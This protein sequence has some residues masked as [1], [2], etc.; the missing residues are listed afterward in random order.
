MVASGTVSDPYFYLTTLLLNTTSTNGAQNNTFQDSSSNTFPLTRAPV[1]GPNAP[2]QGSF[3]PFSQTGWSNYFP[4]NTSTSQTTLT[5]S[6][7]AFGTGN[8]TIELNYYLIAHASGNVGQIYESG[9]NGIGILVENTNQLRVF[10][11]DGAGTSTTLIASGAG[12]AITV[13]AWSFIS[14]I[15]TGTAANQLNLYVN[16][17][18]V[19][20]GT[21]SANYTST[22]GYING[23]YTGA[24]YFPV[25]C[26][27]SNLRVSTTNR[28]ITVPTAF[29]TSDAS[30][31]L[32]TCISNRFVNVV[33]GNALT[34]LSTAAVEPSVQAFSPFAP[35]TAYSTSVIGGSGFFDGTG[36]YLTV[37]YNAAL[38]LDTGDFC[39]EAYVYKTAASGNDWKLLSGTATAPGMFIGDGGTTSSRGLGWGSA[40]AGWTF[41]SGVY[42]PVN[43][44]AHICYT[45]LSGVGRIFLNGY[46][47]AYTA[48]NTTNLSL[49]SSTLFIC[50]DYTN[51]Y[52][53]QG[54]MSNLRITK[55]SVPTGYQTSATTP[56]AT[57][58]IFVPP[59]A[60]VTQTSQGA[61][62]PALI[63]NSINA[64]I[65]DVSAKNN[66]ETVGNAQ[67]S[68]TQTKFGTTSMAY[69][70]TGDY[71]IIPD[72]PNLQ[73]G[74]G[75]F[76][77]D[78]FV[79]LTAAGVAYGIISKGA[80]ATGWSV[81]V[82]SGNKLQF[83]YTA[84][85]LTGA[86]SLAATTWYYFAVTRSGSASGN[87]KLYL[88]T[89]GST[90]LD[91]TSAGAVTDNFNQT[92]RMYVGA[93]RT[94]TTNLNG[95]LD[96]VRV[97]KGVARD[98]TTVPTAVF[99]VQ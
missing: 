10:Q 91:A 33:N 86:T 16:G 49:S 20:T 3:T 84:T 99:P 83:S 34:V 22:T 67:V 71:L 13:N 31:T 55:G 36:D 73:L 15:R 69:D 65:Y 18:L 19:G 1:S 48:S 95:Y 64:G 77:I 89:T 39:V 26:Y 68:T 7:T 81:N 4:T 14:L 76:T 50:S 93:S 61:S 94:G 78:G 46:M 42:T 30:T 59:T 79:Y 51:T 8:F 23:R 58:Q 6:V 2:T 92:S 29:Y 52:P 47:R 21:S 60:P 28:T 5:A 62:S 45:R 43:E 17:S 88:G 82:T 74:T 85:A 96:E 87:L 38:S 63:L 35:T 9:T 41:I 72:S 53:L 75:D 54:Y 32:L 40:S 11:R 70:G 66:L 97:T 44:W 57:T 24:N 12:T 98:V 90:T 25:I 56:S 27:I 37:P 80:A